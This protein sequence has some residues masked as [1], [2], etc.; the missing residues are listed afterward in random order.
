MQKK[1]ITFREKVE[2][3]YIRKGRGPCWMWEGSLSHG[4]PALNLRHVLRYIYEWERGPIPPGHT[5]WRRDH[6]MPECKKLKY[7]CRHRK[8]VNPWHVEAV[9]RADGLYRRENNWD[10]TKTEHTLHY[11]RTQRGHT[12]SGKEKHDSDGDSQGD[13]AL[14]GSDAGEG[15]GVAQ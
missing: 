3:R 2:A 11:L 7:E 13:D 15:H 1:P 8:C 12:S 9:A 14:D 10:G 4:S 5:L 6:R